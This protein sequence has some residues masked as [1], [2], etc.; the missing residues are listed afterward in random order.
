MP[1]V[2]LG[3][4][5]YIVIGLLYDCFKKNALE[6]KEELP[7]KTKAKN[8]FSICSISILSSVWTMSAN[9]MAG[10]LLA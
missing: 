9:L 1:I 3:L 8:I 10:A 5:V 4:V 6:N 7:M 2:V